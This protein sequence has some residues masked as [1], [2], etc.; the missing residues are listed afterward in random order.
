MKLLALLTVSLLASCCG[1]HKV[2]PKQTA[3]LQTSTNAQERY[4]HLKTLVGDWELVGG[5]RLG[6]QV[7]AMQAVPF[8]R[9]GVSSGGH[10][11]TE[12]LFVDTP[13]EMLSVYY[14]DAGKLK[15]DHYCSLG[16]Q[17]RMVAYPGD[18]DYFDFHLVGIS[19]LKGDNE[20]HISSHALELTGPDELTM[21]WGA[22]KDQSPSQGSRYIL[23]RMR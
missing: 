23:K 10:S 5:E 3:P 18:T 7:E 16:N 19:N 17:P 14:I 8:V 11:V 12:E 6:E 4:E 15:M 2:A 9:Y 22:T 20:L 1:S 13:R 21:Y